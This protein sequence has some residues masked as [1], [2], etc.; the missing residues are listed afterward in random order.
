MAVER[1]SWPTIVV[2]RDD[3][4][5]VTPSSYRS[6]ISLRQQREAFPK[7]AGPIDA[8]GRATRNGSF[9]AAFYRWSAAMPSQTT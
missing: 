1:R 3:L 7:R 8:M 6:G 4:C 2:S 9:V 5:L